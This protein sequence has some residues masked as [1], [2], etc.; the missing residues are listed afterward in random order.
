MKIL[1]ADD[2]VL[3]RQG[4]TYILSEMDPEAVK[5]ALGEATQ[6]PRTTPKSANGKGAAQAASVASAKPASAEA[7]AAAKT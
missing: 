5:S 7:A 6:A 3:F 4:M 2:H 1:I